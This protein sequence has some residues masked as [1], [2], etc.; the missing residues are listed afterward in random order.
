[1]NTCE[2]VKIWQWTYKTFKTE[3]ERIFR[4]MSSRK[5]RRKME[6][7]ALHKKSKKIKNLQYPGFPHGHPLQY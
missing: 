7:P 4:R 6:T 3:D 2:T 5:I 1:M